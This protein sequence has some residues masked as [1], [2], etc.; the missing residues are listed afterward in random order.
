MKAQVAKVQE[1]QTIDF[2]SL[3]P[4][5]K[6]K[7]K[8]LIALK[9]EAVKAKISDNMTSLSQ[10]FKALLRAKTEIAAYI[11][12]KGV[13]SPKSLANFNADLCAKILNEKDLKAFTGTFDVIDQ[14]RKNWS[15]NL[16]KVAFYRAVGLTAVRSEEALAK[17]ELKRIERISKQSGE[18]VDTVKGKLDEM[19]TKKTSKKK[20]KK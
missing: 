11:E 16:V 10:G 17:W 18:T 20:V 2:N 13:K 19:R 7:A 1:T 5:T 4:T 6:V 8:S 9:N 14:N 3:L 12:E 15:G